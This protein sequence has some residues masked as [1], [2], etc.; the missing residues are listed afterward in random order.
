MPKP[1]MTERGLPEAKQKPAV[2]PSSEAPRFEF[3]SPQ[4]T[5]GLEHKRVS[6]E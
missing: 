1:A 2:L 6:I 5:A 4:C 3:K